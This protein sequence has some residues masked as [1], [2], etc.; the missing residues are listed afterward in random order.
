MLTCRRCGGVL[1]VIRIEIPPES[2]TK[3]ERLIYDRLCDV[4]CLECK[5]IYYSQPY[6]YGKPINAVRNIE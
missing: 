1:T 6:D 2:L 4:Q 3:Q 5:E